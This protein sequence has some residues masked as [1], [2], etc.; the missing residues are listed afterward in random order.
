MNSLSKVEAGKAITE[1]VVVRDI[2]EHCERQR[3]SGKKGKV[4]KGKS[5]KKRKCFKANKEKVF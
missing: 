5:G 2:R 1:D 4:I 3:A